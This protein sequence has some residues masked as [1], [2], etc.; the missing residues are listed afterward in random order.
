MEGSKEGA[1]KSKHVLTTAKISVF[2]ELFFDA[3]KVNPL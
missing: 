3:M 1:M 2:L